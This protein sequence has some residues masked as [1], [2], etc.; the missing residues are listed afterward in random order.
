MSV[1]EKWV[2]VEEHE[3]QYEEAGAQLVELAR[4][5]LLAELPSSGWENKGREIRGLLIQ[6]HPCTMSR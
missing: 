2:E 5:G 4:C 6:A 3:M 1:R